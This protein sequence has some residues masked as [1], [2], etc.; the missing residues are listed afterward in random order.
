MEVLCSVS[1]LV[2]V[3]VHTRVNAGTDV[4]IS[5]RLFVLQVV[6]SHFCCLSVAPPPLCCFSLSL[7]LQFYLATLNPRPSVDAHAASG[8]A[9]R[10]RFATQ[11][12][13][14]PSM[15]VGVGKETKDRS[16]TAGAGFLGSL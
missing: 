16:Y 8:P 2:C 7:F 10:I 13:G 11:E 3:R 15:Y 5:L 6:C 12:D 14:S 4:H 9:L 1:I